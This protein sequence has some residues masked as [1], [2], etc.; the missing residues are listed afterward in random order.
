MNTMTN[1][2]VRMATIGLTGRREYDIAYLKEQ[3]CMFSDNEY[4]VS[5]LRNILS[6][7]AGPE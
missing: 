6:C 5:V 7:L 4:V 2:M 3:I 1:Q